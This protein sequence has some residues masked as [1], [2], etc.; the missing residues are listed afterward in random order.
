[1]DFMNMEIPYA[2]L[3]ANKES[4]ADAWKIGHCGEQK[5]DPEL[6]FGLCFGLSNF[7]VTL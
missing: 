4:G 1:M 3:A 7:V 5:L 2:N 6:C